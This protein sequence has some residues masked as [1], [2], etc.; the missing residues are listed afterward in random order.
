MAET[1]N[2][3]ASLILIGDEILSGRTQDVNLAHI[4]KTLGEIGIAMREARVISDDPETI[5]A[6]VNELR[7]RDTYVF[8]TGG[9][10]PTHD[11][12]TADCIAE[13]FNVPLKV[14]PV[15]WSLLEAHYEEVQQ[16]FNEARQRMTRI[17]EGAALIDNP[18]SRAP[19]FNIGNV[20]VMA[21]VPKIMQ[22][23]L[24]GVLPTLKGGEKI[25]SVTVT[26]DVPEGRIAERMGV[27]HAAHDDISIGLYPF[28]AHTDEGPRAGVSIVARGRDE[29]KLAA[30]EADVRAYLAEIGA[31]IVTR[32]PKSV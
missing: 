24:D 4:A 28:Y 7:A 20:Y 12:I 30:I 15:A 9:I 19:G 22:A 8:T 10:G 18:V 31:N 16:P 2:I 14:H 11:D 17:P 25:R 23:M 29:G 6:T 3:T 5:I 32:P 13:A 21:G 27:L 1:R 26:A